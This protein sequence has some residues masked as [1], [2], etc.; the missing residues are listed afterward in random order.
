MSGFALEAD[1][2]ALGLDDLLRDEQAHPAPPAAVPGTWKNRWKIA[3]WYSLGIP[4]PESATSKRTV[5]STSPARTSMLPLQGVWRMA[6]PMR[7]E[8]TNCTR[9]GSARTLAEVEKRVFAELDLLGGGGRAM[10]GHGRGHRRRRRRPAAD[11]RPPAPTGCGRN[12]ATRRRCPGAAGSLRGPSRAGRPASRSRGR[13]R[14]RC[15]D[16]STCTATSTACGTRG[17]RW[18]PGRS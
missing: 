8:K 6:L 11:R 13:G 12:P 14:L 10:G 2:P 3:C 7:F 4:S 9:S 18:P 1:G 15:K 16:G 17:R 5:F